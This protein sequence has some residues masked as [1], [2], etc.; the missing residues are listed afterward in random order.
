MSVII[1]CI[2]CKP[3]ITCDLV[4]CGQTILAEMQLNDYSTLG[5]LNV[6]SVSEIKM[7]LE[8]NS[9][10]LLATILN[11]EIGSSRVVTDDAFTRPQRWKLTLDFLRVA[12]YRSLALQH[13]T[14]YG[15]S[16]VSV[17]SG[18]KRAY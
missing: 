11:E 2:E 4:S 7:G 18:Q 14:N 8:W 17:L 10:P 9:R 16:L 5:A 12:A 1:V 15:I 6:I 3:E 13:K